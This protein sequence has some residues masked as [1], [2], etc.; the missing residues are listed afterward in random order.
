MKFL[1]IEASYLDLGEQESSNF[2]AEITGWDLQAV[3]ILPLGNHFE[4][5]AQFG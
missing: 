3:G 4:L 2:S 1:G 5:F